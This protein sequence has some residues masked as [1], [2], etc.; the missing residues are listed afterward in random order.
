MVKVYQCETAIFLKLWLISV[1]LIDEMLSDREKI[2][3]RLG[4]GGDRWMGVGNGRKVEIRGN[5]CHQ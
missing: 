4:F 5:P 1:H 3:W 2:Q